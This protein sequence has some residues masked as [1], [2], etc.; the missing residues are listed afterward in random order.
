[1]VPRA[2]SSS[3]CFAGCSWAAIRDALQ[4]RS[5]WPISRATR[6]PCKD[7]RGS[8]LRPPQLLEAGSH[9]LAVVK[10]YLAYRR[11]PD[12]GHCRRD[13]SAEPVPTIPVPPT[14]RYA[15]L[16]HRESHQSI[17]CMA[18]AVQTRMAASAAGI[19]PSCGMMVA[20]RRTS[21]QPRRCGAPSGAP[22]DSPLQDDGSPSAKASRPA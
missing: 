2:A 13:R 11:K 21:S 22:S 19:A 18:A 10:Q 17:P 16:G 7:R 1:M 3:T 15:R 20:T 6:L 14:L 8:A 4:T 5:L 9:G 12:A